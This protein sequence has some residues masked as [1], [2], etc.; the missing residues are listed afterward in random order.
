MRRGVWRAIQLDDFAKLPRSI[1]PLS[2][3]LIL[4]NFLSN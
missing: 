4:E 3:W 2:S 1:R